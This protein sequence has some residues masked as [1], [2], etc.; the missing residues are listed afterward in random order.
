MYIY[1]YIVRLIDGVIKW[2]IDGGIW[3]IPTKDL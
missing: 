1:H 2:S 3:L